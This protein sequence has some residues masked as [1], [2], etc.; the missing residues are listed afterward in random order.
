MLIYFS[1]QSLRIAYV[2]WQSVPQRFLKSPR[3]F[4]WWMSVRLLETPWNTTRFTILN[5]WAVQ[6]LVMFKMLLTIWSQLFTIL[7]LITGYSST[8]ICVQW[9]IISFG[10]QRKVCHQVLLYLEQWL[11]DP[12]P[13]YD[14]ATRKSF[15]DKA[16]AH[17]VL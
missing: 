16:D 12:V 17:S 6:N 1:C 15:L 8:R 13:V 4:L 3:L 14:E 2:D 10:D 11:V 5:F 7:F 9:L